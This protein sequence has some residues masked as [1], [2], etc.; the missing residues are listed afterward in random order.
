MGVLEERNIKVF[1]K[2][3]N[4]ITLLMLILICLEIKHTYK[5][6]RIKNPLNHVKDNK[7]KQNTQAFDETDTYVPLLYILYV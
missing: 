1:D 3:A 6:S 4:V 5:I 7:T 2:F